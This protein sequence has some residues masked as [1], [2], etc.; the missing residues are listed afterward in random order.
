MESL[1]SLPPYGVTGTFK[2]NFSKI[3]KTSDY[4]SKCYYASETGV[5]DFVVFI[6]FIPAGVPGRIASG[7]CGKNRPDSPP[8]YHSRK[9]FITVSGGERLSFTR[10]QGGN[11]AILK[12]AIALAEAQGVGQACP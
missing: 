8:F 11:E 12:K 6:D 3:E 4:S 10:A 9:R 1:Q 2:A 7:D 5:E